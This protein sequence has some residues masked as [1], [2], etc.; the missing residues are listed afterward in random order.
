MRTAKIT[1]ID[2]K[3]EHLLPMCVALFVSHIT[4][5]HPGNFQSSS[6]VLNRF[7]HFPT[8]RR[9]VLASRAVLFRTLTSSQSVKVPILW[10]REW[11]RTNV[12]APS[13]WLAV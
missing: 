6:F 7:Q 10:L 13:T 9:D 5:H 8:L 3:T 12:E 11:H 4:S 2:H 1:I